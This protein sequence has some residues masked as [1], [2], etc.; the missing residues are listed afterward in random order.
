MAPRKKTAAAAVQQQSVERQIVASGAP[1]AILTLE[2]NIKGGVKLDGL[3]ACTAI[4]SEKNRAGKTAVLDSVRWALT[5]AHPIGPH[6]ADVCGLTA[7]GSAPWARTNGAIVAQ[8]TFP[9]GKKTPLHEDGLTDEQRLHLL[10]LSSIRDLLALGTAKARE[11]L[12]RR[13]GDGAATTLV[14]VPMGLSDEQ[15]DLWAKALAASSGDV[16]EKLAAAGEWVRKEKRRLSAEAKSL[17]EERARI[18]TALQDEGV[19]TANTIK[20]VEEE[21]AQIE[22]RKRGSKLLAEKERLHQELTDAID[23]FAQIEPPVSEADFHARPQV[24]ERKAQVDAAQMKVKDAEQALAAQSSTLKSAKQVLIL[25]KHLDG[26]C[27]VCGTPVPPGKVAALVSDLQESVTFLEGQVAPLL[28]AV[29]Q[30]KRAYD[31]AVRA[32]SAANVAEQDAWR[33]SVRDYESAAARLKALGEAY[34]QITTACE[35]VGI[36]GIEIV[37][38]EATLRAE[39]DAMRGGVAQYERMQQAQIELRAVSR[40]QDVAKAVEKAVAEAT[41]ELVGKVQAKAEGAVNGWMPDGFRAALRLEDTEGKAVCRW[42]IVGS[43]GRSHPKGAASGAEWSALTVALA[44]AW[45]EDAP[46]RILLLDDGDIAGFSA[47]N[48]R[49]VLTTIQ[50]AVSDGKLTQAFV[51]WSR[52]NEIPTEGWTV[53]SL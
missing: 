49:S 12:F 32:E 16:V 35:S 19:A 48:V 39:L 14:P 11:E 27:L 46:V 37:R 40:A 36:T 42:E 38:D 6:Y 8:T 2:S 21:L 9:H 23:A 30:A 28:H 25:R 29:E 50:K 24:A 4:V 18:H 26:G 33:K 15:R 52:P 47:A 43:D 7:D 41:Q 17:E 31:A 51:A 3:G 5:G 34:K 20:R 44:C 13:F 1:G 53:V 10:P 22:A 45:S